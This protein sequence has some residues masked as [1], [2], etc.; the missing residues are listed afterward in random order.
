M[1]GIIGLSGQ[2][3][4]PMITRPGRRETTSLTGLD[5]L[6]EGTLT[7]KPGH[8]ATNSL[9]DSL[10]EGTLLMGRPGLHAAGLPTVLG[11]HREADRLA[12]VPP[13][14]AESG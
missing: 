3:G 5:H 7:I 12:G 4:L 11:G 14:L 2:R 10:R 9:Q 6:P 1:T 13:G 8:R